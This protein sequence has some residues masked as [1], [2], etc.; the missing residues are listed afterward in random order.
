MMLI[1][2]LNDAKQHLITAANHLVPTGED[3]RKLVDMIHEMEEAGETRE[4]VIIEILRFIS[5][6][7]E[8]R[9]WPSTLAKL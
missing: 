8:Y 1:Q 3:Q 9:N 6:G 2:S 7:I 5:N 4:R